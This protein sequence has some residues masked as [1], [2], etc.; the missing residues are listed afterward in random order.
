MVEGAGVPFLASSAAGWR[1]TGWGAA[2]E[3]WESN[4]AGSSDTEPHR[5]N[6]RRVQIGF[7]TC[8]GQTAAAGSER[9]SRRVYRRRAFE[10]VDVIKNK[11]EQERRDEPFRRGG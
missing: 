10:K 9:G 3:V 11:G 6:G 4:D 2:D 1:D 8:K 7:C 5:A